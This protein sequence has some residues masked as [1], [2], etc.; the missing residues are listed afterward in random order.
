MLD[1]PFGKILYLNVL[2]LLVVGNRLRKIPV[3]AVP[4]PA[5]PALSQS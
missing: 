2:T 5:L 3:R 1:D 4:L